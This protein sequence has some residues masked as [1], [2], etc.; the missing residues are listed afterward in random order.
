[1]RKRCFQA[2][3]LAEIGGNLKGSVH[4]AARFKDVRVDR[5]VRLVENILLSYMHGNMAQVC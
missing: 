3:A 2:N 4:F 5:D 1:M